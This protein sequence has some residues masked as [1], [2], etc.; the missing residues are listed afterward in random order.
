MISLLKYFLLILRRDK[1]FVLFTFASIAAVGLGSFFG[2]VSISEV[3][4]M[5]IVYSLGGVRQ[6]MTF[7]LIVVMFIFIK[8]LYYT[9][10]IDII[11]TYPISRM[12]IILALLIVFAISSI[13]TISIATVLC[14]LFYDVNVKGLLVWHLSMSCEMLILSSLC[15]FFGV[16]TKGSNV[17]LFS[18]ISFLLVSRSFGFII[19]IIKITNLEQAYE[20]LKNSNGV[21]GFANHLSEYVAKLIS[22]AFPRLDLFSH[23]EWAV[24]GIDTINVLWLFLAQ[25]VVYVPLMLFATAYDLKKKSI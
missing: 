22:V 13:L 21:S 25:S 1:F 20:T 12:Q 11:C 6:L 14:Y 5:Q 15:I 2:S 18:T 17:G 4:E 3:N 24:Y 19:S 7:G 23:T 9:K 16:L 8:Q 10:E